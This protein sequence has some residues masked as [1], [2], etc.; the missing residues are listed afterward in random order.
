MTDQEIKAAF[1]AVMKNGVTS[2]EILRVLFDSRKSKVEESLKS[3]FS[4][5]TIQQLNQAHTVLESMM[6][7]VPISS[8][9]APITHVEAPAPTPAAPSKISK[10]LARRSGRGSSEK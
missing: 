1:V 3:I 6:G 8:P 7:G 10:A 4:G 5:F 2:H 9:T